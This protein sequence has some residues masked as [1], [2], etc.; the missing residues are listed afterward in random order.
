MPGNQCQSIKMEALYP[1]QFHPIFLEKIWGGN[2]INSILG[3][4]YRPLPNCGESWE[5]SGVPGK[6]S[7]LANGPLSGKRLT[8]LMVQYGPELLGKRIVQQYGMEFPLLLKIL[9][10][11][12]DL[13]IQVHPNDQLAKARHNSLGKTEMWFILDADPGATLISGFNQELNQEIYLEKLQNGKLYDILNIEEVHAGDC[14]YLPAG[15]V[16]TIGKGLLLAEIQQ[17]SD[18][19]YRIY[20]FDRVDDLGNK[21]ELHTE[22]A[23]DAL[24]YHHYPNYRQHYS[25]SIDQPVELAQGPYFTTNFMKLTKPTTRTMVEKD[26][27]IML[28]GVEGSFEISHP[29]HPIRLKMGETALIPA[30][31]ADYSIIPLTEQVSLLESY[32]S[33]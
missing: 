2:K 28:V 19:T 18:V 15:R 33:E 32:C 8:D 24:D 5:I 30:G 10:A 13:S 20:D 16:H 21:R 3:K 29:T 26:S 1:M 25:T 23:L 14:F 9:D 6:V 7:V 4:D 11:A 31:L 22:Q 27:F 12:E 17:S